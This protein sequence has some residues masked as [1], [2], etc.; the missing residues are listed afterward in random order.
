MKIL[1]YILLPAWLCAMPLQAQ[2]PAPKDSLRN[3]ELTLEKEYSPTIEQA[4]KISRLPELHEPQATESKVEFSNYSTAYEAQPEPASLIPK[5]MF[6][7]LNASR[8]DGYA[9]LWLSSVLNFD[10]DAAYRILETD[11]NF[12]DVYFSHRSSN[13]K[14]PSLQ[15]P[16]ESQRFFMNDNWGGFNFSHDFGRAKLSAGGKYT[17]S[18][19]N[20]SGLTVTATEILNCPNQ[21]NN[22][23]DIRVGIISDTPEPLN[24]KFNVRYTGFKQKYLMQSVSGVKENRVIID[25]D[26]HNNY[27]STA[28]YGLSGFYKI[29]GY[30]SLEFRTYN[31][32]S[33]F[34]VLSLSPY[35]YMESDNLKLL[36][37]LR[38][39]LETGGRKKSVVSPHIRF[40]CNP[41]N[42]F[43]V[44]ASALGGRNDNCNYDMFYENRYAYPF[45]RIRDSRTYLDGTAGFGYLPV[46]NLSLDV[47]TGYRL[48]KDEHFFIPFHE[49][50]YDGDEAIGRM[51]M[52]GKYG[53]ANVVKLGARVNYNLQDLFGIDL[54]GTFYHWN[55]KDADG[56]AFE[57]YHKPR[58]EAETDAF[59]VV[60]DMPLRL[61]L[62]F[63]GLF[64]RR[65]L[66]TEESVTKMKDAYDLSVKATCTVAP[67][68]SANLSA[69]NL[70]FQKYDIWYGYS[71]QKFNIMAGISVMF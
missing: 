63:K 66:L 38:T 20:Y 17:Y 27:H 1:N 44:Y 60:P 64:G 33:L 10:G 16:S 2:R 31:D 19:F 14:N 21:V 57:A 48:T 47:F 8:Y 53:T 23:S 65:Q 13:S 32:I 40:N 42:T 37:G 12:A 70:L 59:F 3:R 55:V 58:F 18:A 69:N 43:A 34:S 26:L 46:S 67:F 50:Q 24:Y 5:S 35:Y 61:D 9:S 25:W 62:A 45:E 49:Q 29:Y 36:L 41:S 71:A 4:P 22:M 30:N 54:K 56:K 52:S 7:D 28:E 51:F 11:R 68:L 6:T 15:L 39:D